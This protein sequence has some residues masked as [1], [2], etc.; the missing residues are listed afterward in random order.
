MP[1]FVKLLTAADIPSGG[2]NNFIPFIGFTPEEVHNYYRYT[3]L[4][5]I[6]R[7][8]VLYMYVHI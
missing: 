5:H 7:M 3:L 8:M 2:Q 1:G 6:F 4:V